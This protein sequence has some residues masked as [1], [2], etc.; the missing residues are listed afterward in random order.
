MILCHR[1]NDNY[2]ACTKDFERRRVQLSGVSG[3]VVSCITIPIAEV[4]V[5][6]SSSALLAKPDTGGTELNEETG[7]TAEFHK[8][9]TD[10][11]ELSIIYIGCTAIPFIVT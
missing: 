6:S 5:A 8:P 2:Q 4:S 3:Y 1:P 7:R 10:G 9:D 11:A